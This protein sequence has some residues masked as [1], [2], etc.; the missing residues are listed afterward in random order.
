[1]SEKIVKV[2]RDN[3]EQYNHLFEHIVEI[4]DRIEMRIKI[5]ERLDALSFTGLLEKS[6]KLLAIILS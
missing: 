2:E 5:P 1:M 6:R 3:A 4:D